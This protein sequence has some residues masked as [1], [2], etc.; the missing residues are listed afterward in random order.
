MT[1]LPIIVYSCFIATLMIV[2]FRSD[3]FVEW[4]SLFGLGKLIKADKYKDEKFENIT[5]TYPRF[6]K[7][8][9]PFFIFKLIG[10]Q[11]CLGI[12]LSVIPAII[13]STSLITFI[14]YSSVLYISSL[15]IF[16]IISKLIDENK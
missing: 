7:M 4:M 3:A 8:K 2:W 11:L 16:G 5:I 13:L 10:C 6:L 9:Y 15:F 12:W 1:L 14:G